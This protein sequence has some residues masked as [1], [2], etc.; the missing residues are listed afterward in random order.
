MINVDRTIEDKF[1]IYYLIISYVCN[2]NKK[3]TLKILTNK[4]FK[5]TITKKVINLYSYITFLVTF[6]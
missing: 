3:L 5:K 2:N 6:H 4:K 1:L